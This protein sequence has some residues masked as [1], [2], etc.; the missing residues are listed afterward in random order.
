MLRC[1][2]INRSRERG[3]RG[4]TAREIKEGRERERQ[5]GGRER[6]GRERGRRQPTQAGASSQHSLYTRQAKFHWGWRI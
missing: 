3:G 2:N 4:G 6:G 5:E 1:F